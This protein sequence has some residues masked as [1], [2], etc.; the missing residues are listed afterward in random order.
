[1]RFLWKLLRSFARLVALGVALLCTVLFVFLAGYWLGWKFAPT[2]AARQTRAAKLVPGAGKVG[3]LPR[4][5]QSASLKPI[6]EDMR[7]RMVQLARWLVSETDRNAAHARVT[8]AIASL[9]RDEVIAALAV[10]DTAPASGPMNTLRSRLLERWVALDPQAAFDYARSLPADFGESPARLVTTVLRRWAF[11]DAAAALQAWRGVA[12]VGTP[13]DDHVLRRTDNFGLDMI[14]WHLGRQDLNRALTEIGTLPGEDQSVAWR[15]LA[16][17]A[18]QEEHRERILAAISALSPSAVRSGALAN[19][20]SAWAQAG[21]LDNA[22]Q[23][24]DST[25]LDRREQAG[26][27]EKMALSFFYENPS[28][29]ADWLIAR[30]QSPE[31]RS[32]RLEL[33]T[34]IWTDL[35]PATAGRWLIAQGLDG[36]AAAAMWRFAN[37]IAAN[38]PAEAVIWARSIPDEDMRQRTLVQVEDRIRQ[39]HPHRAGELL[40]GATNSPP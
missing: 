32:Q 30:A 21:N 40:S 12:L 28:N 26:I 20:V 10:L 38:H 22:V 33:M 36:S 17:L 7:Q 2:D 5:P 31:E 15:G 37:T 34:S 19:A 8:A 35:D 16:N 27:E 18:A 23:W 3:S 24:L 39:Q 11:F 9:G 25:Q 4:A 29:S 13:G 14:A 6:Q 1:M